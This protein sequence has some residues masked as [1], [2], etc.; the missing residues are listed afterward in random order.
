MIVDNLENKG[1]IPFVDKENLF[2]KGNILEKNYKQDKK[3][4]TRNNISSCCS[5]RWRGCVR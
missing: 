5:I 4:E 1:S 2:I 3:M